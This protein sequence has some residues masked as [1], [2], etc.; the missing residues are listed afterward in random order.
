MVLG[1]TYEAMK[2][3]TEVGSFLIDEGINVYIPSGIRL[4][5]LSPKYP[6]TDPDS[7]WKDGGVTVSRI[8]RAKGNEANMIYVVGLD[9]VAK[10]EADPNLRNQLFVGLTRSRGWACLSGTGDYP[11][12]N[13]IRKVIAS[14]D[15]FTFTFQRPPKINTGEEEET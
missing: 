8:H 5:Q 10:N 6:N 13:E 15:T 14:G 12:Y 4:N 9:N 7:F 2:L 11:L 1:D 3:E